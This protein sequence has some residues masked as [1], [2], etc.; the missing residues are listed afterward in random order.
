MKSSIDVL[1]A[2]QPVRLPTDFCAQRFKEKLP[3]TDERQRF[4]RKDSPMLP[5]NLCSNVSAGRVKDW[6]PRNAHPGESLRG[7]RYKHSVLVQPS[8][9]KAVEV[10]DSHG[11]DSLVRIPIGY[12]NR[13]REPQS[14][15]HKH[16]VLEGEHV[17]AH[18]LID[19][20]FI[21]IGGL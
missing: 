9:R 17:V 10:I 15:F 4:L 1:D 11:D 5:S 2:Y 6:N 21:E 12:E 7:M 8:N 19:V 14:K 18:A 16:A 3:H 20:A 13:R